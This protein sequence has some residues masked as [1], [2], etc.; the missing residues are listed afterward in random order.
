MQVEGSVGE[1]DGRG[2]SKWVQSHLVDLEGP[3]FQYKPIL[4]LNSSIQVVAPLCVNYN[5]STI[6]D[7]RFFKYEIILEVLFDMLSVRQLEQSLLCLL[8]VNPFVLILSLI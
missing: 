2:Y 5:L 4:Q 6:L 3:A 8:R 1:M 7:L